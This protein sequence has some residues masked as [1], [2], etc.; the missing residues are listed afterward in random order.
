MPSAADLQAVSAT[1]NPTNGPGVWVLWAVAG[2]GDAL[3]EVPVT[4]SRVAVVSINGQPVPFA[5]TD[6]QTQFTLKGD[7][8]MPPP[9]L[10][11]DRLRQ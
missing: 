11:I 10:V 3:V 4:H 7:P 9:V 8:K 1:I 2:A 5:A 6:M